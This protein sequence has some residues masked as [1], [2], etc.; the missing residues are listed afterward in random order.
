MM[1]DTLRNDQ[2][3]ARKAKD[4]TAASLLGTLIGDAV[5][6]AR[7]VENREPTDEEVAGLTRKYVKN[8]Q[9][10]RA[11]AAGR[12]EILAKVD[13]EIEILT[14]YLP[15]QMTADELKAAIDAF[16]VSTPGANKGA[17]MAHLKANFAGLYDGKAASEL[18]G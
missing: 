1:I 13:R 8:A 14:A 5:Q 15:K 4:E 6:L 9:E 2:L 3:A 17:V 18:A 11:S 16:K 7:K 10:T 12:P